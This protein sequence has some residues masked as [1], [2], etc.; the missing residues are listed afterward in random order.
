[1]QGPSYFQL[2]SPLIFLVFSLGF[3]AIWLVARDIGAARLFAASYF[4]GAVGFIVDFI[5]PA[6]DPIVASYASNIPYMLTGILFAAGLF[7]YYRVRTPA[8]L[9]ALLTLAWLGAFSWFRLVEDDI[10]KRTLVM[11][12]GASVMFGFPVFMLHKQMRQK[13]DRLLQVF[14]GLNA[15]TFTVRVL[16]AL[17]IDAPTLTDQTYRNSVSALSLHFTASVAALCIAGLLFVI[18]GMEIFSKLR[19]E[20]NTDPLTGLINRRG[21]QDRMGAFE[22]GFKAGVM[23]HAVV[24]ADLDRFKQ[25]NDTF[26]H[27]AGDAVIRAFADNMQELAFGKHLAVRL[28]GEEFALLL[29]GGTPEIAEICAEGARAA[30]EVTLH[31]QLDMGSVT[32][33]FGFALWTPGQAL[34]DV[35][36]EADQALYRAKK[37]GRNVIVAAETIEKGFAERAAYSTAA[38]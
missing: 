15:V 28:G 19:V 8:V 25:V 13:I 34:S 29:Y 33:S 17:Q 20:A 27:D 14:V 30:F 16:L 11:N 21:M 24:I 1:M 9:L 32:A 38:A 26:G 37:R 23:S 35:L 10:I 12:I 22:H 5:R 2:I 36:R 3:G 18:F 6:L 4:A 7:T 31:P